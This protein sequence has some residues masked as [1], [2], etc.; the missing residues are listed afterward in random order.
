M[1]FFSVS[2][3]CT[4]TGATL[5][6]NPYDTFSGGSI[7]LLDA[8]NNNERKTDCAFTDDDTDGVWELADLPYNGALNANCPTISLTAAADRTPVSD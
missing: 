3:D 2:A 6:V 7:Y 4:N 8:G 5:K 1:C